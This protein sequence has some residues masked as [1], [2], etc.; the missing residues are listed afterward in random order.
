VS[1]ESRKASNAVP[2]T[3]AVLRYVP[4]RS[5]LVGDRSIKT[6]G[7]YIPS[8]RACL[9]TV[10]IVPARTPLDALRRLAL[11]FPAGFFFVDFFAFLAIGTS[12]AA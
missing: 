3:R 4:A 8:L 2:G 9:R 7:G 11:L 5:P 12:I 10:A 6:G 1:E